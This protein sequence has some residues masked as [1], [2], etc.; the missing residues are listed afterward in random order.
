[1]I[2]KKKVYARAGLVGNPSDGYNG[3]TIAFTFED[4]FAEVTLYQS[5]EIEFRSAPQDVS[6]F[7]GLDELVENVEQTGYYGGIRLM[8]ASVKKFTEYCR[9]IDIKLPEKNFTMRY[10]TTIP[11]QVGLGGSSAIIMAAMKA[12]MDFYGVDIPRH[13]LPNI[14]LSAETDELGLTA[15]LQ[16]RVVQA[17]NGLVYMDFNA[18]IMKGSGAGRYEKLV[19]LNPPNFYVAYRKDLSQESS[20]AHLRVRE[21]YDLGDR[22]VIDT[23]NRIAFLADEAKTVLVEG[24]T[25]KLSAILNKNFDLRAEI[26]PITAANMAMVHHA[27]ST[28]AS[29]KF[30]GSGGSVVG[31]YADDKML[32]DLENTLQAGQYELVIPRVVEATDV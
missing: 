19:G 13:V 5:P 12:L 21:R 6:T 20:D 4:F 2:V 28:G 22:K 7:R 14:V 3:K 30:C 15:G 18:E 31:T 1:M 24:D 23:M 17:Y 27:R 26:Y 8:K 29:C 10:R 25:E 16:D 32:G 11:R 9:H